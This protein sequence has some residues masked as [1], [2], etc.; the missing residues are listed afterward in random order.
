[1]ERVEGRGIFALGEVRRSCTTRVY[2]SKAF[3]KV[4]VS[5]SFHKKKGK[6]T[7]SRSY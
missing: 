1:M 3:T 4:S 5:L 2:E 6:L 7:T